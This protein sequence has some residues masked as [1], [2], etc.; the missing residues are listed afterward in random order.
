MSIP[1]IARRISTISGGAL[2]LAG[3]SLAGA[4][5]PASAANAPGCIDAFTAGNGDVI[6]HSTCKTNKRVKVVMAWGP[7][8]ACRT[9]HPSSSLVYDDPRGRLD[10]VVSC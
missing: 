3:L 2:L 8:Q 6:V 4:A 7:D 10:K 1:T 5:A 9:I